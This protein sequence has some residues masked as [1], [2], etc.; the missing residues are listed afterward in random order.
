MSLRVLPAKVVLATF[1]LTVSA[2]S[3]LLGQSQTIYEEIE[4]AND[5]RIVDCLLQ[6]TI[7][8]LGNSI[9]Q[10]PPRPMKLPARDCHIRGGDFLIYDRASYSASLAHWLALAK[11]GDVDAQ[12]YVAEIFERGLGRDPD[13]VQ[14]AA[15]YQRAA[16]SGHPVA[17]ISLAQLYEKGLGVQQDPDEA[18]R[19]YRVAFG[20]DDGVVIDSRS[21]DDPADRLQRLERQLARTQDDAED[22]RAQLQAARDSLSTAEADLAR[23][24]AEEQRLQTELEVAQT[25]VDAAGVDTTALAEARREL[26]RSNSELSDQQETIARLEDEISR[27][28]SQIAAYD[29]EL[30]RVSELERQLRVQSEQYERANAELRETR[31]ALAESNQRLADQQQRF[32]RERA[33]LEDARRDLSARTDVTEENQQELERRLSDREALLSAQGSTLD[34][35]RAEIAQYQRQSDELQATLSDLRQQNAQLSEARTEAQRYRDETER[36]RVALADTQQQL[37]N[38]EER[39]AKADELSKQELDRVRE[40]AGRYQSRISELEEAQQTLVDFAGPEIQLIEPVAVNTRSS[41]DITIT[42]RDEQ[43]I[44][45]RV[46]APAGLLTLMINN[47]ATQVNAN[48]VFQSLVSLTGENTP[49]RITAIDNQGKRGEL[50]Y[51]LVNKS[52]QPEPQKPQLP[53]V[54]FG[55]FHALLIG[56]EEYAS[57]PDLKTP[58]E[59]INALDELLRTRYGFQTTIIEDGSRQAIMDGMYDL[60][61]RLTSED[62]LL[63]YYAG[64]G[65]YVTDTNRGVWLPVDASRTSP[66]NWI[67]NTDISDY[68][69]QI[70]AKQIVLIADS[71]YSGAL[72]RSAMINLRPGLTDEE[73]EEHLKRMAKM[74]SRVVLTSGGLA[75]VLDGSPN[76]QHSIF[77]AALIEIL[78]QNSAVLSA[79]DLGRTIA[80]KV[81]LAANRVGYDQEPQYAPL[82]HANHQGGDFFFVPETI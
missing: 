49:V 15:W 51:V 37:V 16:D 48:N 59:D 45:G 14:A 43:A 77:A 58:K 20:V 23:R 29:D 69:K 52:F 61:G 64:H 11:Q 8:K 17:Q 81:S 47:E 28:R 10:A 75:P 54:S 19:L 13:Y 44:I 2:A 65:E 1:G 35:M 80:A 31:L 53:D 60:L 50:I 26:D 12:I 4:A 74:R 57:L 9:Y 3:P 38:V 34:A 42:N 62:N 55:N 41:G 63:I 18:A 40:E 27:N 5:T 25:A 24:K 46:T 73:Y 71:C 72:T 79:Q 67:T 21:V 7:R 82:N 56:N 32:D 30:D 6:G 22:L 70:R 78:Q 68:L 33:A 39:A 66:A 36:L 76:S